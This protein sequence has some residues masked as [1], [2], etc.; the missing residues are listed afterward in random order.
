MINKSVLQVD[1]MHSHFNC[2]K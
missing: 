1:E 2:E